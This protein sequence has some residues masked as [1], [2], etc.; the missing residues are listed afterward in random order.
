MQWLTML[1]FYHRSLNINPFTPTILSFFVFNSL[2][3]IGDGLC[4]IPWT[5]HW[6]HG[7]RQILISDNHWSH[8]GECVQKNDDHF[9]LFKSNIS[10]LT[11][12]RC[13]FPSLVHE[14]VLQY[15]TTKCISDREM[16]LEKCRE[17][18]S[19]DAPMETLFRVDGKAEKCPLS[20]P[21]NFTYQ[22]AQGICASRT[23]NIQKCVNEK[24]LKIQ[25]EA[26]PELPNTEA[27][28]I[29]IECI[30]WWESL[31]WK[32]LASRLIQSA[33]KKASHRCIILDGDNS[34]GRLG[35]SAD[36]SCHEL[37][38]LSAASTLI[39]YRID[40]E[41]VSNCDFP[42]QFDKMDWIAASTTHKHQFRGGEW[43]SSHSSKR[44]SQRLC[45]TETA[46]SSRSMEMLG[47]DNEPINQIIRFF[48]VHVTDG[49]TVGYQCVKMTEILSTVIQIEFGI[50]SPNEFESCGEEMIVI[51]RETIVHH[52][53]QTNCPS[54]GLHFIPSC[55]FPVF[56][57]GCTNRQHFHLRKTC[58]QESE[59]ITCLATWMEGNQVFLLA[60][61]NHHSIQCL[62]LT[63]TRVRS[64][65]L[66]PCHSQSIQ[67]THPALD[68]TTTNAET[69]TTGLF[70]GFLSSSFTAIP[71]KT[72]TFLI[73]FMFLL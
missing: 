15:K 12:F 73:F 39:S 20:T 33:K 26:C 23:S 6:W 41:L 5:S 10:R 70:A 35:I 9:F 2:L 49:C 57:S 36:S 29:E 31:G 16:S 66:T 46:Q 60:K 56:E 59:K 68:F 64:F 13:V 53:A 24:R 34:K 71:F 8:F 44:H 3:Q 55:S 14:N 63:G 22:N 18:L 43:T 37:T 42:E 50:V 62:L 11:C 52:K 7:E 54:R 67:F 27:A 51:Q 48:R 45:L 69:C 4:S 61:Q 65:P 72:F 32:F 17:K 58:Q 30:G 21:L 47:N 38:H 40:T 25:Y 19:G 1:Y 28:G